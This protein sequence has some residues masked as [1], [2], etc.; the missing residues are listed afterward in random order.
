MCSIYPPA[1]Y[2]NDPYIGIDLNSQQSVADTKLIKVIFYKQ[3][4]KIY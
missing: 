1:N 3:G 2:I 4:N